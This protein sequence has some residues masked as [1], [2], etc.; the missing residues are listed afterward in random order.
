MK[1]LTSYPIYYSNQEDLYYNL[2]DNTKKALVGTG[3]ATASGLVLA[4][5]NKQKR[6]RTDAEQKCGRKPWFGKA[7]KQAWQDC[8]SSSGSNSSSSRTSGDSKS[9]GSKMSK[10]TIIAIAVV[11]VILIG[12]LI[13]YTIK[14][15]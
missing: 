2:D 11:G 5:A 10:N 1:I 7:K 4:L 9:S 6:P 12:G 14:R 15:K 8:I 13:V 3:I